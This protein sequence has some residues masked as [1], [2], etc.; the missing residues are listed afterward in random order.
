MIKVILGII[1]LKGWSIEQLVN[2]IALKNLTSK[3]MSKTT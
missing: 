3:T 1:V 2:A